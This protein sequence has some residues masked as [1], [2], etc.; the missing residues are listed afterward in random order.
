MTGSLVALLG[1]ALAGCGSSP[2]EVVIVADTDYLVPSEIDRMVI[3]VVGP[4][5]QTKESSR[6]LASQTE[7]PAT[8][9]IVHEGGALGPFVATL[10]G[11][12]G[13]GTI[14]T[15]TARFSFVAGEIRS[16]HM[17]LDRACSIVSCGLEQTCANGS[18]R[19]IDVGESELAPWNGP[20]GRMDGG[21]A[22]CTPV[23]E[24]CN[25]VD[26][27]CDDDVD[28]GFDLTT[29]LSN[30]GQCG[31]VCDFQHTTG[32]CAGGI[33]VIGP[34]N[35]GFEN[36]D[37][38]GQNGCETELGTSPANCGACG[39]SCRPPER[40]CCAGSCAREC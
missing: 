15:R 8:L 28:E 34:C 16:L 31:L 37:S 4:D 26:D 2:T 12:R 20:P 5:G 24:S 7:L 39:T 3:S 10:R 33:C 17:R 40:V 22:V 30:C 18:C 13:G 9:G 23:S 27:D 32:T 36:C 14:A 38:N 6:T 35:P 29:D 19:S 25:G 1:I 21:P 11:E